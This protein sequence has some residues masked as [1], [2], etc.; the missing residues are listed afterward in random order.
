MKKNSLLLVVFVGLLVAFFSACDVD[1]GDSTIIATKR[2]ETVPYS[3]NRVIFPPGTYP[4][5]VYSARD[6]TNNYYLFLLG[7]VNLVPITYRDAVIYNGQTPI[8]VG[9]SQ[10][11]ITETSI[12]QAIEN[13]YEY[14][15]T[16]SSVRDGKK[17]EGGIKFLWFE[18][19]ASKAI[20]ASTGWEE[21]E[22]RS[23]TNTFE[24]VTSK[25]SG[26]S[27]SFEVTIGNN[28]QPP[29]KYRFSLFTTT[30]VYYVIV[31]NRSRTWIVD[32]YTAFCARPQASW[33]WGVDYEP[34]I[35][36]SFEK[37]AD[38][39]LLEIPQIN[40]SELPIPSEFI[41]IEQLEELYGNGGDNIRGPGNHGGVEPGVINLG[42][43]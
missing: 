4:N 7:H 18:I 15:F 38:G 14:S 41:N 37:T 32:A 2:Y 20:S 26:F 5:L 9:Y 29:G 23:V 24:T 6:N 36:G 13:T 8:T 31:T 42:R 27:D 35:G 17:I 33:A 11:D 43:S 30:D 21:T 25:A 16:E 19:G 12:R 34:D 40:I 22:T 39:D 28:N 10:S 3:D 1:S